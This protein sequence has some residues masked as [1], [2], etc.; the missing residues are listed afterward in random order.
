MEQSWASSVDN[1]EYSRLSYG[2]WQKIF[3]NE[4]KPIES[5]KAVV[6]FQPQ[7]TN[8]YFKLYKKKN[9]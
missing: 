6:Y 3:R 4:G 1:K 7:D 2:T 8:I 5:F 9:H